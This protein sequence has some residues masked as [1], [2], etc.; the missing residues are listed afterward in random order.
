MVKGDVRKKKKLKRT[1]EVYIYHIYIFTYVLTSTFEED[2]QDN[3][4]L[5]Q[6]VNHG[7]G[8]GAKIPLGS[9]VL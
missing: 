1:P 6:R 9:N 3:I 5:R 8:G 4:A 2:V 7:G